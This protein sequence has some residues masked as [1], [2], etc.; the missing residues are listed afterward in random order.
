MENQEKKLWSLFQ[1]LNNKKETVEVP[2]FKIK[3]AVF[4]TIDATSL[5]VDI[6]DLFTMKFLQTQSEVLEIMP[7]S[8]NNNEFTR[9][10]DDFFKNFDI[11]QLS[12]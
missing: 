2:D 6:V 12:K 4:T 1:Q 8:R 9:E 7:N 5:V 11:T 10:K 3:D